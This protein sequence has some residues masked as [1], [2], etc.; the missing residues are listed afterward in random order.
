MFIKVRREF[1]L[2]QIEAREKFGTECT[3]AYSLSNIVAN[4]SNIILAKVAAIKA[5]M[6]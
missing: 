4:L 6:D 1:F 2:R 3:A 5:A